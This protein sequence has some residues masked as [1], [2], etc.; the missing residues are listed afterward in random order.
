[1]LAAGPFCG[2]ILGNLGA[3]I[4]K[5]EPPGGEVGRR[6]QPFVNDVSGIYEIN[7]LNKRSVCIDTRRAE[8]REIA[9]LVIREC[10][11]LIENFTP[12]RLKE[13]GLVPDC[14]RA[15]R[16]GTIYAS[17]SGFGHVGIRSDRRA[18]DTVVQ[19]AA[20]VMWQTGD[21]DGPPTKAGISLSDV[22]GSVGLTVG[23]LAALYHRTSCDR[24]ASVRIDASM[25]DITAW[26]TMDA[27]VRAL[28][29]DE[30]GRSGNVDARCA[31]Q[32][33]LSCRDGSIAVTVGDSQALADV[34]AWIEDSGTVPA[35]TAGSDEVRSRMASWA[36]HV[37]VATP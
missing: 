8:G 18:Y 21:P 4:I 20:G 1:M 7:N 13:W 10:D 19:A 22:L 24:L 3:D 11:V 2:R 26:T 23:V 25:F 27:W 16:S 28:G 15:E 9:R 37:S 33:I 30:P 14:T 17:V 5:I 6:V 29:G 35:P 32:D 34:Q 36:Q 12:G 31:F